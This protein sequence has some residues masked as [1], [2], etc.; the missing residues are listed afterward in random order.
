MNVI[1]QI[2]YRGRLD[3]CN[4]SCSY[5]PFSKKKRSDRILEQDRAEWFR[6]VREIKGRDFCGAIQV[7]PY[8]EAL[9]HD[10]Y[11]EG[12][13]ELSCHDGVEAIGAQS[14][15]SFPVERML[16]IYDKHGGRRDK[17]RLWGTFH[18]EMTAT[19]DFLAQCGR[20]HSEGILLCVGGVGVP[21]HLEV[22]RELR[23]GLDDGIYMWINKMDGLGR[24]YK[25]E[26]IRSFAAMDDYFELEL[27]G[28]RP[29]VKAC[30]EALFISGDGEI[31]PCNRCSQRMGNLYEDSF[32]D[33]PEKKCTRRVCDCFLAYGSRRDIPELQS[34]Q[35]FPAFRIPHEKG[36]E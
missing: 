17:L 34:F 9:I 12:M 21:E 30:G 10:H 19:E 22:L 18:P 24:R 4:Y 32:R 35:P 7:V 33:L 2:Y 27:R 3:F 11:W 1:R 13:A 6:F 26:E 25:E 14:N 36:K 5:C 28:F 15:L 16:S 23:A 31:R 8:G 20:L 29:D